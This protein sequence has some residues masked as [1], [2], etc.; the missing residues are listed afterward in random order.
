[1][2]K[3]ICILLLYILTSKFSYS[4]IFENE[5]DKCD[6]LLTIISD[7]SIIFEMFF[8]SRNIPK[9]IL[10]IIY[11]HDNEKFRIVNPGKKY[12]ETDQIKY[13]LKSNRRLFLY[14]KMENLHVIFIEQGGMSKQ[15]IAYIIEYQT[16]EKYTYCKV[17]IAKVHFSEIIL[18]V[19]NFKS[20]YR[21][22]NQKRINVW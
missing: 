14:T 16:D 3:I 21:L 10:K 7:S 13:P 17:N 8:Y 9:P 19:F 15:N 2:K 11:F 22:S 20:N 12:N 18:N 6:S 1:M 5:C 4:Q